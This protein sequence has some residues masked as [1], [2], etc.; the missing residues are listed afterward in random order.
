[1][2]AA[3]A[4]S[5]SS[6]PCRF[7]AQILQPACQ[8]DRDPDQRDIRVPVRARLCAHLDQPDHRNQRSEIP[9]PTDREIRLR[10]APFQMTNAVI[11]ASA[12]AA[13]IACH[14]GIAS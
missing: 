5:P 14:A 1:M 13:R 8:H 7:A 3:I 12:S 4:I 10:G 6:G 9:E 2:H 11:A